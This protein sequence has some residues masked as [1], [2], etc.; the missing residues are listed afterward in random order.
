MTPRPLYSPPLPIFIAGLFAIPCIVLQ[1]RIEMLLLQMVFCLIWARKN[2]K[3]VKLL[4]FFLL[5]L[6]VSFFHLLTPQGRVYFYLWRLPI[7]GGAL[8]L[9][10]QKGMVVSTLVF[11]SLST[12]RPGI[13]LPGRFGALLSTIF[14]Y[15]DILFQQRHR[16]RRKY[17]L[18]DIDRLLYQLSATPLGGGAVL[19]ATPHHHHHYSGA[20]WLR[21]TAHGFL[22]AG[23]HAL[24]VLSGY[25]LSSGAV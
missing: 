13:R 25:L 22:F 18:H 7:T 21:E 6:S 10:L 19:Q 20:L 15:F 16:I 4:Y 1:P 9:G 24:A 3:N 11:C 5:I 2:G 12:V 23:V 17:L 14:L 8:L